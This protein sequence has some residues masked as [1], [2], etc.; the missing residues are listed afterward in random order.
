M[1]SQAPPSLKRWAA[2]GMA[3]GLA[4]ALL[5]FAPAAWL[6]AR[7]AS[8]TEGKVLLAAARGTVWA[9][10][11]ELVFSGGEGSAGA[12]RLPSRISWSMTPA[13]HMLWQNA[14]LGITLEL[15]AACCTTA[16]LQLQLSTTSLL[17]A[18]SS[19]AWRLDAP[20][21]AVPAALL[22]GL[23]TPWNT[24]Q[25]AGQLTLQS[26]ALAGQWSSTVGLANLSGIA[27]LE[28]AY[29]ET[30]LS[31]VRPLGT[32]RLALTGSQLQLSTPSPEDALQMAGSGQ[33]LGRAQFTGEATAAAG[34]EAALSNLLHIIGQR[35]PSSDGRMRTLLRIG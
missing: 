14:S 23:G 13:W 26:Q 28:A 20:A 4:Y 2:L 32:Y 29:I 34:R 24:L 7:V 21:L 18:T 30:A 11:A 8:A 22:A 6:A 3:L 5:A 33:L 17:Q 25:L 15:Q 35:Q 10:S 19:V 12:V 16:P 1:L 27:T 31:T 9:G